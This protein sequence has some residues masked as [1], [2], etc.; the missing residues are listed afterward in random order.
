MD[1]FGHSSHQSHSLRSFDLSGDARS[2][3]FTPTSTSN[4]YEYSQYSALHL[5]SHEH[6]LSHH[7]E[8][9]SYP[10]HA[11]AYDPTDYTLA[12]NPPAPVQA[13]NPPAPVQ[14]HNPPAPVQAHNPPAPAQAPNSAIPMSSQN[15]LEPASS[16]QPTTQFVEYQP[17][18]KR[19]CGRPPKFSHPLPP[20]SQ[21]ID[22][23]AVIDLTSDNEVVD[24][25]VVK[26]EL[27]YQPSPLDTA[28]ATKDS[29]AASFFSSKPS[30]QRHSLSDAEAIAIL[31]DPKGRDGATWELWEKDR[32]IRNIF[33]RDV[34]PKRL[35]CVMATPKVTTEKYSFD[36]T[37]VEIRDNVLFGS[38]KLPSINRAV[39]KIV[40]AFRLINKWLDFTG[41]AGDGDRTSQAKT[42]ADLIGKN[43]PKRGKNKD[44]DALYEWEVAEWLKDEKNGWYAMVYDKLKND[45]K[46]VQAGDYHN[47][48]LSPPTSSS[49][50]HEPEVSEKSAGKK[51]VPNIPQPKLYR[52]PVPT[53]DA[54]SSSTPSAPQSITDSASVSSVG[55]ASGN[56]ASSSKGAKPRHL[57]LSKSARLIS[58]LA[59]SSHSN[60]PAGQKEESDGQLVLRPEAKHSQARKHVQAESTRVVDI[61][62]RIGESQVEYNN[63]RTDM[64]KSE[65]ELKT[66]LAFQKLVEL[67]AQ[68][69]SLM[70]PRGWPQLMERYSIAKEVLADKDT[71]KGS[72][73][74]IAAKKVR[75]QVLDWDERV[76]IEQCNKALDGIFGNHTAVDPELIESLLQ[77]GYVRKD[78]VYAL[79]T[80]FSSCGKNILMCISKVIVIYIPHIHVPPPLTN[81]YVFIGVIHILTIHLVAGIFIW[82]AVNCVVEIHAEIMEDYERLDS[83]IEVFD[84]L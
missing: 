44:K 57:S 19:P 29:N 70:L 58:P 1:E 38:R 13:H 25:E 81:I 74:Y 23:C 41:G 63:A 36:P 51:P 42:V 77:Q 14:A 18:T 34:E 71:E 66:Q 55:L 40:H 60:A 82:E 52:S 5:G 24:N 12:H 76:Y 7:S 78:E 31:T 53:A 6:H 43:E 56:H 67:R 79:E 83:P 59:K 61:V 30:A 84:I 62:E 32:L 47:R 33:G 72:A 49:A 17:A 64:V 22:G 27:K 54:K 39:H 80:E 15:R 48:A 8:S 69:L 73:E 3:H 26:Q 68:I 28:D 35:R 9:S 20:Q 10:A 75:R 50:S 45:P 4:E 16:A 11:M 46:V 65:S 2:G 37:W 21:P